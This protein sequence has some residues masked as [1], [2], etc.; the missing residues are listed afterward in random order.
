LPF[1]YSSEETEQFFF[2]LTLL[3]VFL[4][5]MKNESHNF[6]IKTGRFD[7]GPYFFRVP[8]KR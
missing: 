7:F 8:S 2:F 1:G 3:S 6:R 4:F 5:E